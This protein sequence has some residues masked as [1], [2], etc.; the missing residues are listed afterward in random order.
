MDENVIEEFDDLR[1]SFRNLWDFWANLDS[2]YCLSW[3]GK[4]F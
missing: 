2:T 4:N 1:T 3:E